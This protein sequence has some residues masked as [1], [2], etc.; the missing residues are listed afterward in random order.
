MA[1][2][3]M[4]NV[5]VSVDDETHRRLRI[6]AAEQGTSVSAMIRNQMVRLL[7]P[8][9]QATSGETESEKH[10]REL[11]EITEEFRQQ[12]IGISMSENLTREELYQR[13]AAR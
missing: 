3:E 6:M 9:R 8:A 13:N 7:E 5:S 1:V 4:K 11:R 2:K 10:R 12:G